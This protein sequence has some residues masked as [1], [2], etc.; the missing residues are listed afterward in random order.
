MFGKY[1]CL[2]TNITAR[3]CCM[4]VFLV[5]AVNSGFVSDFVKTSLGIRGV[6]INIGVEINCCVE[7]Y[8]G[9]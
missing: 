2:D 8:S 6:E 5:K 7:K 9:A 1:S 3:G 4:D